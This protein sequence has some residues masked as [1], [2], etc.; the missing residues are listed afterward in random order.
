MLWS[1]VAFFSFYAVVANYMY[2]QNV[3]PSVQ[4]IVL[5]LQGFIYL[6]CGVFAAYTD[7]RYYDGDEDVLVF[8]ISVAAVTFGV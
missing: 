1:S 5:L 3:I 8:H 7:H 6:I 2:L 4:N